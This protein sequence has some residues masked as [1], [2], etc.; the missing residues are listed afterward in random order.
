MRARDFSKHAR[1][2]IGI[3]AQGYEKSPSALNF[4]ETSR[5]NY[6]QNFRKQKKDQDRPTQQKLSKSVSYFFFFFLLTMKK[7]ALQIFV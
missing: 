5:T 7:T 1:M 6:P 4:S 2:R 3:L